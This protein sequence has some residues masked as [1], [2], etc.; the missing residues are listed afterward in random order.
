MFA[1]KIAIDKT[2]ATTSQWKPDCAAINALIMFAAQ[3]AH[4]VWDPS[5]QK[6]VRLAIAEQLAR[7]RQSSDVSLKQCALLLEMTGSAALLVR[8]ISL[9]S[10]ARF[11]EVSSSKA[12]FCENFKI[13]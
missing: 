5:L 12:V 9:S 4:D 11:N 10:P 1:K 3:A 2:G 7:R 6:G 8:P 13:C